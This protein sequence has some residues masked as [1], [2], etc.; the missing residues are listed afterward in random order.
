MLFTALEHAVYCL[1]SRA[2]AVWNFMTSHKSLH[3]VV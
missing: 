3:V 1:T 2:L